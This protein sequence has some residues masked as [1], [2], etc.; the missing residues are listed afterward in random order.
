MKIQKIR[1]MD[2]EFYYSKHLW[3]LLLNYEVR[4]TY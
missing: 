2:L 3:H 1:K 4:F